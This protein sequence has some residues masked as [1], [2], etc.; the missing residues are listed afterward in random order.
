MRACRVDEQ[1]LAEWIDGATGPIRYLG[2]AITETIAQKIIAAE[3]RTGQRCHVVA[4]V[5]DEMDRSGYGRTAGVRALYD[6]DVS[7]KHRSGLR[8]AAL[9]VPDIAVAWSPIAE[10]VDSMESVSVNGI[11][12]E[13]AEQLELQSWMDRMTAKQVPPQPDSV[14]VVSETAEQDPTPVEADRG[15]VPVEP[16]VHVVDVDHKR[17]QEVETRLQQHPPRDFKQEKHTQVYRGY[18]GFV[19]IYVKGSSLAKATTLAIPSELTELGLGTDLRDKLS[20]TMRIDL[21]GSVELGARDVNVKVEAFRELFTKKMGP[22][23][24][25]IYKKSEWDIMQK[26]WSEIERLVEDANEKIQRNMY[27]AVKKIIAEAAEE[28]AKAIAENPSIRSEDRV[29]LDRIQSLLEEQWDRKHRATRMKV[30]LFAKDLTWKTLNN[31][32]VRRKIEE[33]YPE[34]GSTGLYKSRRAWA[35]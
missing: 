19:E 6:K 23:L 29:T 1:R 28:W 12:M 8:I 18:V 4:D 14:A 16:A 24:G 7:V 2:P 13:G 17:V 20:E 32:E 10:R 5:D 27:A 30:E 22:P 25:R 26:K 34:L 15:P 31:P 3:K 33:A 21:H 35:S 11:W 9:T